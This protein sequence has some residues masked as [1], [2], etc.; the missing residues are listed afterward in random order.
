VAGNWTGTDNL[1]FVS[2]MMTTEKIKQREKQ[3]EFRLMLIKKRRE[4]SLGSGQ[5]KVGEARENNQSVKR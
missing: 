4:V 5:R 1:D 2:L 3:K